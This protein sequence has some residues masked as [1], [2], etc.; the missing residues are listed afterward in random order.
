M[1]STDD[2]L[3]AKTILVEGWEKYKIIN[4]AVL[5]NDGKTV[6]FCLYNPFAGSQFVRNP[7]FQCF[8]ITEDDVNSSM[9]QIESFMRMRTQNL[10]EYPLRV[11]KFYLIY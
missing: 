5:V 3:E 4:N 11:R 1:I 9:Q 6:S 8:N 7:N 10:Q 2:F